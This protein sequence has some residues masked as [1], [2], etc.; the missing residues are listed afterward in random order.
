M[1]EINVLVIEDDPE[2]ASLLEKTINESGYKAWVV[3]DP[4]EGLNLLRNMPFAV[5]ITEMRSAKMNGVEVTKAVLKINHDV[6]VVTVTFYSFISSAVEAMAVGAYG[7]ITKPFNIMEI[8]LVT[9]RAVERHLLLNNSS[10]KDYYAQLSVLDGLTGLYNRRYF[11]Q[12]MEIEFAR[13]R[14]HS[15]SFSVLMIDI[16]NFKIY[17]DTKATPAGD[18]LLKKATEVF[19]NTMREIDSICRYGGEEFVITLPQ[20]DKKGA[21]QAA[22]RLLVQ[23]RVYLANTVSI[24]IATFPEDASDGK[25]LIERADTALYEAKHSGKNRWCAANGKA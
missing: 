23:V 16:D 12:L 24:G 21:Q 8:K 6:N 20:T 2:S 1:L 15:D 10:E 14:R 13:L 19:K 18:A 25:A 22:D 7:Y 5:V 9:E 11:E 4:Q 3:N 17:N